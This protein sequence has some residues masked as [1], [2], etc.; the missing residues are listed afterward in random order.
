MS[1]FRVI[2]DDNIL[3]AT[4]DDHSWTVSG[5]IID[6]G[7]EKFYYLNFEYCMSQHIFHLL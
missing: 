7:E 2:E 6:N 4:I 3:W 5:Y 1:P